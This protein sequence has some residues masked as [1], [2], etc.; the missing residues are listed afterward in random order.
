MQSLEV[1]N[2]IMRRL[3]NPTGDRGERCAIERKGFGSTVIEY[4]A[5]RSDHVSETNPLGEG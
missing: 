3:D 5:H 4:L 1:Q 2:Q